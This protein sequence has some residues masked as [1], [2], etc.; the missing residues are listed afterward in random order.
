M[1][2]RVGSTEVAL[3]LVLA[4]VAGYY[5]AVVTAAFIAAAL[6]EPRA[7]GAVAGALWGFVVHTGIALAA[8]AVKSL[9]RF[10]LMLAGC[11]SVMLAFLSLW[12]NRFY[13]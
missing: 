10:T 7:A 13:V 6:G 8:F 3:R 11:A 2:R 12:G 9:R 4:S 1:K 5:F